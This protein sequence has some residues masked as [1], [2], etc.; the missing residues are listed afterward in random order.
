MPV[1]NTVLSV[2]C[3]IITVSKKIFFRYRTWRIF[4]SKRQVRHHLEMSIN[5][6]YQILH[7]NKT[8]ILCKVGDIDIFGCFFFFDVHGFPIQFLSWCLE[9]S[10]IFKLFLLTWKST[11]FFQISEYPGIH[12]FFYLNEFYLFI[13]LFFSDTKDGKAET[14]PKVCYYFRGRKL[15]QILMLECITFEN[16]TCKLYGHLCW[17]HFNHYTFRY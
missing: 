15:S 13:Y 14:E 7:R 4:F 5:Q 10:E 9:F 3:R 11:S 8:L 2:Q 12:F 17:A 6:H 16:V 1:K